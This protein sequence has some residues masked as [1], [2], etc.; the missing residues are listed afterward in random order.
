[1]GL[2]LINM[3]TVILLTKDGE[4]PEAWTTLTGLCDNHENFSYDYLKQ[5]KFPFEYKG[6]Q[7][8]KVQLNKTSNERK[9]N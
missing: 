2:Y 5:K 7:F 8:I 6:Y 9:K 4:E 1:M 3:K